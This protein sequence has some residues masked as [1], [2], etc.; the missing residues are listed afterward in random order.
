MLPCRL[1]TESAHPAGGYFWPVASGDAR[2]HLFGV[3]TI[4]PPVEFGE[5]ASGRPSSALVGTHVK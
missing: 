5:Q 3:K 2:E 4:R 1:E